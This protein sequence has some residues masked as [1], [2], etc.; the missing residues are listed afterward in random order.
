MIELS[1]PALLF[2]GIAASPHCGLMC[3]ALQLSQLQTRGA[4][5]LPQA[6]FF[7]HLG[8]VTGYALLGLLAGSLGQFL[9]R[10]LPALHWGQSIQL[11]AAALLIVLGVQQLRR[12]PANRACSC[13]KGLSARVLARIPP[14]ARMFAQGLAWAMVPCG[15]LYAVVGLAALSGSAV[16]GALLMA[17]FGLGSTPLLS[18]SGALLAQ[19]GNTLAVRRAGAWALVGMGVVSGTL[20]L[21]HPGAM[22]AWCQVY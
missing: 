19:I 9:L 7:Q 21:L 4:L 6:L 10:D 12:E 8:R 15:V 13:R 17:A 18:G 22:S 3:G 1:L 11:A 2:A 16:F 14:R 5:S 20:A